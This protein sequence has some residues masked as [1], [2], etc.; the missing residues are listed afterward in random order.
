MRL[1]T[2]KPDFLDLYTEVTGQVPVR[3]NLVPDAHLAT[4][5]LQN[6]I[7][8]LYT[9]DVD[10]RRFDFLDPRSPLG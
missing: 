2:E 9:N 7:R 10:F 4:I 6:G 1:I 8:M 5:L 3:G